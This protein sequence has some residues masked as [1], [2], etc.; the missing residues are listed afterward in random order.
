MDEEEHG[1]PYRRS[2]MKQAN[3]LKRKR[4]ENL[5]PLELETLAVD[6]AEQGHDGPRFVPN[7]SIERLAL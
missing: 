3:S 7:S 6:F 5:C 2:Q 4:D 1:R